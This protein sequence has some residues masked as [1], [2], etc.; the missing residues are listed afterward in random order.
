[1]GFYYYRYQYRGHQWRQFHHAS[2]WYRAIRLSAS[3]GFFWQKVWLL[4]GVAC[5]ILAVM[6]PQYGDRF[7]TVALTGRPIYFVV[8]T[9]L[10]ML[11]ED[12]I[13]TRFDVATYHIRQMISKM[14]HDQMAIIPYASTAYTYLPLTHDVSAID[15]FLTDMSVGMIGSSGSNITSALQEVAKNCRLSGQSSAIVIIF[16]DGEFS[17]DIDKTVLSRYINGVQLQS[18]IVGIGSRQGEPIPFRSNDSTMA[19]AYKK[20]ANGRIVISKQRDDQ[21]Q[22]LATYLNGTVMDGEASPLV[23]ETVVNQLATFETQALAKEQRI[24]RVDR[25]HWPLS[26]AFIFIVMSYTWSKLLL[27]FRWVGPMIGCL[28]LFTVPVDAAHPANTLYQAQDY[29]AAKASFEAALVNKPD[30]PNIMHNLGNTYYQLGAFDHAIQAYN[31]ALLSLNG[32][33][34]DAAHYN[35][36]TAYLKNNQLD[37]AISAYQKIGEDSPYN[38]IARQNI[39]LALRQSSPPP[40]PQTNESSDDSES[41]SDTTDNNRDATSSES[42]DKVPDTKS[43]TNNMTSSENNQDNPPLTA[44][45]IQY[46]VDQAERHAREK[47]RQKVDKLFKEGEW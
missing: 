35:L 45:Q 13:P 25:Y 2:H 16:S 14:N 9:S 20:D 46:L 32:S 27:I 19:V 21:L 1:V 12:G 34:A 10:S 23:A 15:L 18:I 17:P 11:A 42:L 7:E 3:G 4:F 44:S 26:L 41:S 36:G 39:E 28:I 24:T 38:R 47:Q 37:L 22:R 33:E 31:D 40:P 29:D 8:D 6:R 30:H 5:L 43:A